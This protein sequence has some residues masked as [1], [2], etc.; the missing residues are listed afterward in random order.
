MV[1]KIDI[2]KKYKY[3]NLTCDSV[4]IDI[5]GFKGEWAFHISKKYGCKVHIFEPVR[6]NYYAILKKSWWRRKISLYRLAISDK[7]GTIN[8]FLT[9]NADGHS[10]IDRSKSSKKKK[11]KKIPVK[12]ITLEKFFNDKD[13]SNVDLIKMNCEGAEIEILNSIDSILA[14][15]IQQITFSGHAPK[16][17][18]IEDHE[19]ALKHIRNVGYSVEEYSNKQVSNRYYCRRLIP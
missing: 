14:K 18:N 6:S 12:S 15:K 16:I 17:T 7:T 4:V 9:P 11:V 13:L 19:A 1:S 5:G 8:F 2:D 3:R 10:V